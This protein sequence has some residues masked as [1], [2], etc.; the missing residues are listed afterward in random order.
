MRVLIDQ[1]LLQ[2]ATASEQLSEQE[3]CSDLLAPLGLCSI[4]IFIRLLQLLKSFF[5]TLMQCLF[6]MFAAAVVSGALLRMAKRVV[7]ICST[8]FSPC[9]VLVPLL[10]A[11]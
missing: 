2:A 6:E 1:L 10:L 11:N 3:L 8:P 7:A 4:S 9:P 5:G